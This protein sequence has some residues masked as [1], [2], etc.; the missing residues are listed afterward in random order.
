MDWGI[1]FFV[2][3]L[4]IMV[5]GFS[6][7]GLIKQVS[8]LIVEVSTGN[9][10]LLGI[11]LIWLV[12]ILSSL[13][14][15]IPLTAAIIPIVEEASNILQREVS[16]LWWALIFGIGL[17]ANYTP[18]GSSST[19]IALSILRKEQNVA[20][21]EFT[22]V[23]LIVCTI[24]LLIGTAYLVLNNYIFSSLNGGMI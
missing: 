23:G 1:I 2:G 15:D 18:F 4:L 7:T 11:L 3:P 6:Q 24:Q 20:F 14:V 16:L 12:G 13:I 21:S 17:G 9:Y 5:D 10:L 8:A 22:R 19:I